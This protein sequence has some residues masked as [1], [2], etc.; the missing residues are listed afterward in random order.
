MRL[1][2]TGATGFLGSHS[3]ARASRAAMSARSA[4]R[5]VQPHRLADATRR[6][7]WCDAGDDPAA[8]L[9]AARF[10]AVVH[11]AT[12]YGRDGAPSLDVERVQL[13]LAMALL[14]AHGHAAFR[15]S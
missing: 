8:L 13:Q 7:T 9:L 5:I 14:G 6:I 11:A 4:A 15:C 2:L 1:L 12:H 10:D 3:P